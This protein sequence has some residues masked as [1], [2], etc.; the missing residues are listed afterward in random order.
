MVKLFGQLQD[1]PRADVQLRLTSLE[2]VFLNIAAAAQAE[3]QARAS[4]RR[5]LNLTRTRTASR[6]KTRKIDFRS[7]DCGR[8]RLCP[9]GR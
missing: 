4:A 7:L 9:A 6:S 8:V 1:I 5:G 3:A 2:E